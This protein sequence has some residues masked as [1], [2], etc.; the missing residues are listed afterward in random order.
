MIN[1]EILRFENGIKEDAPVQPNACAADASVTKLDPFAD[2]I[3][4]KIAPSEGLSTMN[5]LN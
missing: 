3:E 5:K 2:G 1:N 4:D